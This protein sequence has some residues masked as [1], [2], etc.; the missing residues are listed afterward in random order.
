MKPVEFVKHHVK[1]SGNST[2]KGF[3]GSENVD[4]DPPS[5]SLRH[6]IKKAKCQFVYSLASGATNDDE[7]LAIRDAMQSSENSYELFR[8][9]FATGGWA[10]L[11]DELE[12]A[13]LDPIATRLAQVL[14]QRDYVVY[15]LI[16]RY[17]WI[18]DYDASPNLGDC[19]LK[20]LQLPA[21]FQAAEFDAIL[22][23]PGRRNC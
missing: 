2:L 10:G 11:D 15:Q 4:Y 5:L 19:F 8:M 6:N 16:R 1:A 22:A 9:V 7:E 23:P 3:F 14:D 18:L 13:Y 12:E 17:L 21:E 20:V